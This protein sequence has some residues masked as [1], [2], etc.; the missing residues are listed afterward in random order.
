MSVPDSSAQP[1][2]DHETDTAGYRL[3]SARERLQLSLRDVASA[4]NLMVSH[5]RGMETNRCA[6]LTN[7]KVFLSH[8]RGYAELVG[9]D[10]DELVEKYRSQSAAAEA[11]ISAQPISRF[12]RLHQCGSK[13]Y[14]VGALAVVCAAL[15]F[16]SLQQASLPAITFGFAQSNKLTAA[17]N[18]EAA[19]VPANT[20]RIEVAAAAQPGKPVAGADDSL[21]DAA[22]AT[23]A[24]TAEGVAVSEE[25]QAGRQQGA[26]RSAQTS[27]RE[28]RATQSPRKNIASKATNNVQYK[29]A[30]RAVGAKPLRRT[31]VELK[32]REIAQP[33]DKG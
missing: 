25:V 33:Q 16:W 2:P 23:P 14:A 17:E 29:N 5:V 31:L 9:L 32:S 8:M 28:D 24:A 22:S 15:G 4:L 21:T 12:K 10:A 6:N 27:A 11:V 13:W 26:S 1:A 20:D 18:A 30:L 7:D 19:P 3:C